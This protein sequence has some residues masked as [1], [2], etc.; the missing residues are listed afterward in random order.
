[1]SAFT[2]GG[3][4]VAEQLVRWQRMGDRVLLRRRSY[5]SYAADSLPIARS[6]RSSNFEP[7][8]GAFEVEAVNPETGAVV[9]QVN[10]LFEKDVRAL[11]GLSE[12]R[13]SDFKVSRLDPER[14]FIDSMTSYPLNV[15]VRH[16]LTYE[17][18]EPP[19]NSGTGTISMQMFQSMILLPRVGMRPR[20]ADPRVGY[21][22][23]RQIDYGS[24]ELGADTRS[25]IQRWR[26]EPSDPDA[27][28]RGEL[29]EPRKPIVYYIDPATPDKWR[30]F[31]RAGIEDWQ[32]A[33][34][35]AGFRNAI[36]AAEPDSIDDFDPEDVR[37]SSIRYAAST[38]RN[39]M[40]PRVVDPRSG[41]IIESDIFWYHNH[42]RSYRNRLMVET[43]AANP[44]VRTL[45]QA[46]AVIGEALR[47][48]IAHEVGHALGLPHNMT[49][50]SAFPVD[51]LRSP[52]FTRRYGVAPSIMDYARQNYV[53]QPGD[54]VTR[55]VRKIGPY[56]H[57]AIE[58][59]YRPILVSTPEEEAQTLNE[60]IR[61]RADD[62]VYRFAPSQGRFPVDPRT[63][64][65]DIGDDPVAASTY[66][67]ANLKRVVPRLIGWTAR[68][69]RDYEDLS[70]LYMEA[71]SAWARYVGHVRSLVG[72]VYMTLKA[73]DQPGPVFQLVPRARQES[74]MQFLSDNVFTTPTWLLERPILD[75]I[76]NAGEFDRISDR[77]L[78]VLDGLLSEPRLKR[79]AEAEAVQPGRAYGLTNLMTDLRR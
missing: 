25:F 60:W 74:A 5:S 17:A 71:V 58:W 66:A 49:A 16:T 79:L 15:N 42:L 22:T 52:T 46:E 7:I 19:S 13:R 77:Q 54:G 37:Y 11:S 40:G 12:S 63:Q 48:V 2:A 24:E 27:F 9:I 78:A 67:V 30:P 53:A 31:I 45:E 23:V 4:K 36:I 38:T 28:A 72:G 21:L 44:D 50:S 68:P 18:K 43:G 3:T 34:E 6:V 65:E 1:M 59:G 75:R 73:A 47:Q 76:E 41:E 57:H 61:A 39:A 14:S 51:S 29:V 69:G 8:V 64:T 20:R 55:F 26:L 62:P 33:F 70:E 56:D 32:A 35:S 10:D